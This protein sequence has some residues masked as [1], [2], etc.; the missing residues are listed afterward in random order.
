MATPVQL[1]FSIPVEDG[2]DDPSPYLGH[3]SPYWSNWD[4]GKVGGQPSYLNPRDVPNP[5]RCLECDNHDEA[6]NSNSTMRLACQLYCPADDVGNENAYHRS[7]YVFVCGC[8]QSKTSEPT[9]Q[10][11]ASQ[12]ESAC[13]GVRVLRCQLPKRNEFYPYDGKESES[14]SESSGVWE[15]HR[16]AFWEGNERCQEA[17]CESELVVEEEPCEEDDE[18]EHDDNDTDKNDNI[19]FNLNGKSD[20]DLEQADFN[21]IVRGANAKTA[22]LNNDDETTI[23]FLTRIEL[24]KDQVLRYSRWPEVTNVDDDENVQNGPLWISSTRVPTHTDIPTC[25]HCGSER[26]FEFQLMP[27]MIHYLLGNENKDADDKH[28]GHNDIDWGTVA[29]YTCTSSCDGPKSDA[30]LSNTL[31]S[32][33]EEFAWRQPPL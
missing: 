20:A 10:G 25:I 8:P 14:E 6:S 23:D 22:A 11:E 28:E 13:G 32:Y 30:N 19:S 1:G 4:G 12:T 26:K 15:K 7:I 5:I 29:V 33:V 17:F 31:G 9:S 18:H 2:D 27:Q 21:E 16:T 24:A 3:E